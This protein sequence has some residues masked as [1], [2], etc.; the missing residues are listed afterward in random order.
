LGTGPFGKEPYDANPKKPVR[1]SYRDGFDAYLYLGPL[2]TEI[3]SPLIDGF[4]TD[5]FVEEVERRYRL[6][7][8][9]GWAEMSGRKKLD[10]ESATNWM[11]SVWGKPREWR[12]EMGPVD[13]WKYGDN[14]EEEIRKEKHE[15]AFEKSEVI[16]T[17]ANQLFDS[18]R[19]VDYKQHSGGRNWRHFL[20][21]ALDYEVHHDFPYWV[22]W[23]CKTFTGNPI[24]SVELGEV[25]K[26]QNG[27]PAVSYKVSLRDGR[28]L[29]GVLPFRYMPR[30]GY[31]MGIQGIDWHLQYPDATKPKSEAK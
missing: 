19:N 12:N 5:E 28:E 15:L 29:K 2:E 8:G 17:A 31:W 21:E 20:P 6:M 16:K 14:W 7:R 26:G 24:Q 30:E 10:G 22:Q 1:S 4:Y 11:K 27:L 3:Y 18:I 25:S 23:V 13:A 9:K